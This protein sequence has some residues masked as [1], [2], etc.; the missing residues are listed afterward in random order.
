MIAKNCQIFNV[1]F[2]IATTIELPLNKR[3]FFVLTFVN[4]YLGVKYWL[5]NRKIFSLIVQFTFGKNKYLTHILTLCIYSLLGH[6]PFT[7]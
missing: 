7:Y 4:F 3:S 5:K 6:N 1:E 2:R